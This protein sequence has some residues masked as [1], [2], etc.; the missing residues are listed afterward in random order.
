MVAGYPMV[1]HH[2]SQPSALFD[3]Y[4]PEMVDNIIDFFIPASG[5]TEFSKN[6]YVFETISFKGSVKD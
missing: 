3:E 4:T 1:Q 5:E 6:Y 2:C